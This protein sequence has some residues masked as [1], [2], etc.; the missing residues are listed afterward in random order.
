MGMIVVGV[1]YVPTFHFEKL[2]T[3]LVRKLITILT[4]H[5]LCE[6][7][8][9]KRSSPASCHSLSQ[10]LRPFSFSG[11]FPLTDILGI[12]LLFYSLKFDRPNP[13]TNLQLQCH[14]LTQFQFIGYLACMRT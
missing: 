1:V 9:G 2:A 4:S 7:S 11:S 5:V 6:H 13:I 10:L 3:I 12:M 8:N 14:L